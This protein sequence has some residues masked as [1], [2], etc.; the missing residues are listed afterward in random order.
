MNF[1]YNVKIQD[2]D[3]NEKSLDGLYFMDIEKNT[4][5]LKEK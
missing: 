2:K 3:G 5:I 1:T 4:L